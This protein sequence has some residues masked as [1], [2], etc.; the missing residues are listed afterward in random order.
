MK[1]EIQKIER[2]NYN[3]MDCKAVTIYESFEHEN[4]FYGCFA[5]PVKVAN[6]NIISYLKSENEL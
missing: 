2:V 3:G 5:V 6:K 4:I 1:Y